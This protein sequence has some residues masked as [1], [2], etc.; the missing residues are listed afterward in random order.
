MKRPRDN[1]LT[2]SDVARLAAVSGANFRIHGPGS[3]PGA[4]LLE[5]TFRALRLR[6]GLVLHATDTVEMESLDTQMDHAGGLTCYLFLDGDVDLTIGDRPMAVGRRGEMQAVMLAHP[7]DDVFRRRSRRGERI[8]KVNVSLS[9]EWLESGLAGQPETASLTRFSREHLKTARWRPSPRL[10]AL[11]EQILHPPAYEA[12]LQ[13]LYLESRA[14]EIVAEAMQAV[15]HDDQHPWQAALR[16]RDW[17]R[18][19]LI[20]E[21]LEQRIDDVPSL[22]EIAQQGGF[23]VNTLQ[24][25]FRASHGMTVF[26]YVR[27][28]KLDRAWAELERDGVS[29]TEAAFNAG[30][31]SAANF[32]TAF[33][34][35]FGLSPKNI[36][37]RG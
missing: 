2:R 36:R 16:P 6:S 15:A 28:R 23:S 12:G 11:A 21:F 33:K 29:I 17:N 3:E 22:E 5:G 18:L 27:G 32:A 20:E 7:E 25:L 34:R 10:V 19:R 8:R 4:T 9:R 24:R 35:R 31:S 26:E 14:I 13:A 30:Y 1:T 37:A